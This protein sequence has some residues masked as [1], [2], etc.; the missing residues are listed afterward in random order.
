MELNEKLQQLRKAKGLTQEELATALYVSR[1]AISKWESGRGT[2]NIDSLKGIADFFSVSVDDLLSTDQLLT[3]AEEETKRKTAHLRDLV[4]GLL[5]MSMALFFFL[6]LFGETHGVILQEVSLLSLTA[7][8][9]YV[10]VAYLSVVVLLML[11]GVLTLA[12]QNANIP[13]WLKLKAPASLLLGGVGVLVFILGSQPYAAV[14]LFVLL[15]I[16]VLLLIKKN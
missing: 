1:T 7:V 14:Y 4:F 11:L 8:A 9:P 16:K 15:I 5:D 2:P 13:L 12:L 3:V 6:P 10:R